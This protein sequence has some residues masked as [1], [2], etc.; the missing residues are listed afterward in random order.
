[1]HKIS[2]IEL[3]EVFLFFNFCTKEG[4]KNVCMRKTKI[5]KQRENG[6]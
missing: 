2:S 6:I 4:K 3:N 1:M 5:N